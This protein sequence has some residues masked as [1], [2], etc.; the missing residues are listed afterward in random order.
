M[1][2]KWWI[3]NNYIR[4]NNLILKC[5]QHQIY[6]KANIQ[7]NLMLQKCFLISKI[8]I[9]SHCPKKIYLTIIIMNK[10]HKCNII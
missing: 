9:N 6:N 5:Y 4:I 7:T 1:N 10:I 3:N 8:K 2:N